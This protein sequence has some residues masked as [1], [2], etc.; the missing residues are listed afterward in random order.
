MSEDNHKSRQDHR[1]EQR[2]VWKTLATNRVE[3]I[4]LSGRVSQS[5]AVAVMQ[6]EEMEGIY[7]KTPLEKIPW[8]METPAPALVELIEGGKLKPCKVIDLGCGAGNC[9]VYLAGQG[10][11]ATGVNISPAA[12]EHAK[13][14]A[15]KKSVQCDFVVLDV[16][17]PLGRYDETFG[18]CVRL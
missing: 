8:N 10:F 16:L 3:D 11:A 18:F 7:R 6:Q 1:F 15:R 9:T 2:R 12:I 17:G 13:E 14:N 4:P 5:D